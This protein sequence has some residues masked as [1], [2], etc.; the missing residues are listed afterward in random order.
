MMPAY[1]ATGLIPQTADKRVIIDNDFAGDP[2]GLA[3]LAHQLLAPITRTVLVTSSLLNPN[4][5]PPKARGVPTAAKGAEVANELIARL[6]PPHVPPVFAGEEVTNQ[7]MPSAAARA[8][9]EETL[10][11]D[12]LPLWFTCGGPLTNLAAALRLEPKI[13]SKLRLVWIGGET[14]PNGGWEYNL[15]G[16]PD[17]ARAVIES[18]IPIWQVTRAGYRMMEISI[19]EFETEIKPISPFTEWLYGRFTEIPPFIKI[20]GAYPL[21][22]SPLVLLTSL[23][24]ES[25]PSVKVNARQILPDLKYGAEIPGHMIEVFDTPDARLTFAD[26]KARLKIHALDATR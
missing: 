10:R 6:K 1:A 14:Y 23:S 13:A 9:V 26:F 21:G 19:A 25:S 3:A 8:I 11:P 7:K 17:A 12:P 2:D 22:D 20:P 4:F 18:G 5:L 15:G 24:R 16:D